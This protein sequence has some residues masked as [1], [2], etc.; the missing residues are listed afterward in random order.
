MLNILHSAGFV[1][2]CGDGDVLPRKQ[3]A[4]QLLPSG[5]RDTR[6]GQPYSDFRGGVDLHD[7]GQY[8]QDVPLGDE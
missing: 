6:E 4:D 3:L 7:C 2:L 1:D 8:K 5:E